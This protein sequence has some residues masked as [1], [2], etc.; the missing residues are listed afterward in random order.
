MVVIDGLINKFHK[1]NKKL[2]NYFTYLVHCIPAVQRT[3]AW[4]EGLKSK[5]DNWFL[6]AYIVS[7]HKIIPRDNL[8]I[9]INYFNS[10]S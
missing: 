8:L 3:T 2:L 6:A 1:E 10:L 7:V 9:T 4:L 5:Q